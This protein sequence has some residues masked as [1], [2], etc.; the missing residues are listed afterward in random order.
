MYDGDPT[1]HDTVQPARQ[2]GYVQP[3]RPPQKDGN[4]GILK[5][6]LGTVIGLVSLIAVGAVILL[7]SQS[8]V[9][10]H[11]NR[12]TS[13]SNSVSHATTSGSTKPPTVIV[14]QPPAQTT[15]VVQQPPVTT[16]TQTVTTGSGG[17]KSVSSIGMDANTADTQ[18]VYDMYTSLGGAAGRDASG[19][20]IPA[21]GL[22]GPDARAMLTAAADYLQAN[23]SL[24]NNTTLPVVDPETGNTVQVSYSDDGTSTTATPTCSGCSGKTVFMDALLTG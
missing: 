24:P 23:G 5:V 6:L 7:V 1:L 16:Q 8:N 11:F 2:L 10:T 9:S 20:A 14:Q 3:T 15:T 19:N 18:G 12:S 22:N 4:N 21:P 17:S 13:N